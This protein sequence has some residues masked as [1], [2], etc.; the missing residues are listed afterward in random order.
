MRKEA[1]QMIFEYI[2]CFYNRKRIHSALV[3]SCKFEA[4]YYA[5]Q[6]KVAA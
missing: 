3:S 5:N 1:K 2:E 4:A 6:G